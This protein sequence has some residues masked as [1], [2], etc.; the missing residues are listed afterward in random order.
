MEMIAIILR[1]LKI[2]KQMFSKKGRAHKKEPVFT[3]KARGSLA[4]L[5]DMDYIL[6]LVGLAICRGFN[7]IEV[8]LTNV[9]HAS[10][11]VF[12]ELAKLRELVIQIGRALDFLY[13]GNQLSP[14]AI[15]YIIILL[16]AK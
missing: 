16:K 15:W 1:I 14:I 7:S 5:K 3:V 10:L 12:L 13:E 11:C 8:D 2:I 9:S 4:N 6:K